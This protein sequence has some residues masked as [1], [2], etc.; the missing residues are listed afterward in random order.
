MV[1][2]TIIGYF[3]YTTS[4]RFTAW[5]LVQGQPGA[6]E[7]TSRLVL[8]TKPLIEV[9]AGTIATSVAFGVLEKPY[10]IDPKNRSSLS[11]CALLR[12]AAKD[13]RADQ[14]DQY[15]AHQRLF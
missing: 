14:A 15:P 1:K 13:G 3:S 7:Q 8:F 2:N 10:R 12:Q 4:P 9:L 6:P 5:L 11:M